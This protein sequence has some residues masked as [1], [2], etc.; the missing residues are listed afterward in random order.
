M[1]VKLFLRGDKC[2]SPKCPM[3]KKPYPPGEKKKRPVRGF[4]EFGKELKEKQ[5]LR[6]WYNIQEK[7][8]RGYVENVLDARGKIEDPA[9]FLIQ[10]MEKRLDNVVFR[11][12]LASS[13]PKARQMVSHGH[14]LVN[15]RP[16][17]IPSY[18]V[19]KGEKISVKQSSLGKAL[20]KGASQSLKKYTP[21]SW[22]ELNAEK[23]E[24]KIIK[25][26]NIEEAAPPADVS[27]VFEYYS[28]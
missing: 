21:P 2:L 12:G 4:S 1:G 14:F 6:N 9:E 24:G 28:R 20:F 10:T 23:L 3:V 27:V 8:F 11:M 13:R 7:Q 25:D 16:I 18:L 15:G 5:K 19:R 22:I 26:P 17:N